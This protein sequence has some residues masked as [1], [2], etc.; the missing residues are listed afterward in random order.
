MLITRIKNVLTIYEHWKGKEWGCHQFKESIKSYY[1]FISKIRAKLTTYKKLVK[2]EVS[3]FKLEPKDKI[4][5]CKEGA[6][7]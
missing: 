5:T 7:N 3:V 4:S 2:L 6:I 1:Q